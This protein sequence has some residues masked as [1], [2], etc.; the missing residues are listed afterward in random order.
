MHHRR[1]EQLTRLVWIYL[2]ST[3]QYALRSVWGKR[4]GMNN[5]LSPLCLYHTP[6]SYLYGMLEGRISLRAARLQPRYRRPSRRGIVVY[7]NE[8]FRNV[9]SII[10]QRSHGPTKKHPLQPAN[11]VV[12]VKICAFQK[13]TAYLST[14]VDGFAF[15]I[16]KVSTRSSKQPCSKTRERD[17]T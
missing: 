17:V 14:S 12:F 1:T 4:E 10:V 7:S 13:C 3:V 8:T 11:L 6:S 5:A 9:L 16:F 15:L 2:L